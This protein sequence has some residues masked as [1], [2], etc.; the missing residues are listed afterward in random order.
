MLKSGRAG[1]CGALWLRAILPAVLVA[2]PLLA[3]GSQ[4]SMAQQPLRPGEAV[5][6]RF[7]GTTSTTV[8][9]GSMTVIDPQGT[10]ASIIDLRSPGR[11]PQGDHWINE[12]QRNPVTANQVGQVF[13]VALDN[14][15][16]PNIYLSATAA[17]G[18]HRTPDNS[19]WMRGMWGT[20][21]GPGTIYKLDPR[22]GYTPRPFANVTLNGRPNSGA[23]LGNI[24]YDRW[25][26]QLFVSDMETGM[27]HRIRSSDG[28]DLGF[29]DHGVQGRSNFLDANTRQQASLPP[30]P[31]NPGSQASIANC[32]TGQ[33][34]LSPEC[35]NIAA[36]GRRV[37]GLGVGRASANGETRLYYSVASSPDLGEAATWNSLPDD[38]KRNQVW[39]IK[40]GQ[41]GSFDTSDIR[42][43]FLVPDF[44][45]N[46]QDV[47]RAGLS[48]PVSDIT[49]PQCSD[50]PVMLLAERGG[51]RNLGLDVVNPFAT[52]HEA[53]TLRYELHQDG[54]WRPVGRYDVGS[55][56]RFAEGTPYMF[57]NCAGGA[58]FGYG[59]TPS[60]TID[61]QQPNQYVWITGDSLCSPIGMCRA[62][63][64]AQQAEGD[65]SEVH[66]IQGLKENLYAELAPASAY[67]DL[68]PQQ[69]YA[70]ENVGLDQSYLIDVDVNVDASG[71]V[72]AEEMTRDDATKIG[73]IA[74][75]EFCEGQSYGFVPVMAPPPVMIYEPG[76]SP[77]VSHSRW[78]S[79]SSEYSHYRYGSHWPAMS[80]N[81]YGSH[82]PE[83]SVRHWPPGSIRHWP[84][85]SVQHWPPG[86]VRHWPPGSIQHWPPGSRTHW[87]PGSYTHVPL[88]SHQPWASSQHQPWASKQHQPTVSQQ[89]QPWVSKQHQPWISKQHQP[90]V[91]QQHQ[92]WVSK[93][94]Q[95]A[96][97]QQHQPAVS[98]QHQP[99]I[100]KQHQPAASAQHQ[101][102]IS[103]QHQPAV[104]QQHQPAASSQHQPWVSKQHQPAVSQQHQPWISKQQHLPAVS[105]Q[106]KP[107]AS[108]Q[109]LPAVSQ[110]HKPPASQLHLP[111]VSQQ[112]KPPA[113]QQHLPAVSQQHKPPASQQHLP[114]VSQQHQPAASQQHQ[115]AVSQQHKPPASQQHLPA[116]SQQHKPPASQLHLPAACRSSTLAGCVATASAGGVAT[117]AAQ[118]ACVAAASAGCVATAAAQA[119]CVATASAGCIATAAAQAACVATA[120]AGCIAA[121]A[122]QATGVAAASTGGIAT[123]AAQ[124]TRIGATASAARLEA[125]ARAAWFGW[126]SSAAW[127]ETGASA[128]G[129][130]TATQATWF[131][132]A[133]SATW[134][135]AGASAA[136]LETGASAA[137]FGTA[138]QATW[139]GAAASAAWVEAGASAARV[140][141]GTSAGR[142]E[143]GTPAGR[144]EAGTSAGRLEAGAPT[145]GLEATATAAAAAQAGWIG[146]EVMRTA[147]RDGPIG[148]RL[149]GGL[150]PKWFETGGLFSR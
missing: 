109:H 78:G 134:L 25:N 44:F 26:Q 115:P 10:S 146:R 145:G 56:F 96:A 133:A 75:Y 102:W 53:R 73:D 76:H 91:S 111:A 103:K 118:A 9:G 85:G 52:P 100:S 42:R 67:A 6:T 41:D 106:H 39:S 121:A 120:S 15:S 123:A 88:G 92:P 22:A 40:I 104:S 61:Q 125:T 5:V 135:E 97:S 13:G 28:A 27:I 108:Q 124:A 2:L 48:R 77:T 66:G 86:S 128:A 107:P 141:A 148:R 150:E 130:G 69:G 20:S 105:Q 147:G 95:P 137:G 30:I 116:V 54:V 24:A 46:P 1:A 60:W 83:G 50:K 37:W 143:T 93:Q 23:A 51:I 59:Y 74:I 138:T 70:T 38:E 101:P 63:A 90:T 55:Y 33:F 129:F 3:T 8:P 62:P 11:P 57:A 112:H 14:E 7:S 34:Q 122:A 81:R 126:H 84:P 72:I 149:G 16:S 4:S 19:Q 80:H 43:E 65:P 47:A 18:L 132:A 35:W 110:Q 94:H 58:A 82:W 136:W 131:G 71:S 98:Q 113:S 29:Y 142:L 144:L 140:E 36:N 99:W 64:G 31:F 117:A 127:F 45:F 119:A 17:F 89:H 79:H 68:N 32:P 12:P 21:G 139:F 87:P 114:A 49:F